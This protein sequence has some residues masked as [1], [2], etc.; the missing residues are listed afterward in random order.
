M[1]AE[2]LLAKY[3]DGSISE[4]QKAELHKQYSQAELDAFDKNIS[5]LQMDIKPAESE[6]KRFVNAGRLTKNSYSKWWLAFIGLLIAGGLAF[7]FMQEEKIVVKNETQEKMLFAMSDNTEI[8][9]A[10]ASSI[11]YKKE[12]YQSQ[13]KVWLDGHAYFDVNTKGDFHV[14]ANDVRVYVLGTEFDVWSFGEG[15]TKIVCTEG[16]VEVV[17]L[18][19]GNTGILNANQQMDVSKTGINIEDIDNSPQKSWMND[20]LIFKNI[21]LSA[22]YSELENYYKIKFEGDILNIPFSGSL[23]NNDLDKTLKILSEVTSSTYSK[24]GNTI[25]IQN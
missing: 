1:N 24:K 11:A 13:R 16:Q 12:G 10:P 8:H 17:N 7:Y 4:A 21:A 18:N 23:P 22:V 19:S 20:R 15:N 6:W 2:E 25:T 9:I 5:K 3:L 14:V